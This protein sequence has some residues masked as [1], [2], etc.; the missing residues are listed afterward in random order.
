MFQEE[1]LVLMSWLLLSSPELL[2]TGNINFLDR[3]RPIYSALMH[4]YYL[5]LPA[6][7][8]LSICWETKVKMA[9]F[10]FKIHDLILF[11]VSREMTGK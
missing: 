6:T 11:I 2:Q 10:Y 5:N 9:S 4:I 3:S 1:Q 7:R 8:Q